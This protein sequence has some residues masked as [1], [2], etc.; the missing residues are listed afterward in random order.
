MPATRDI[1]VGIGKVRL[2]PARGGVAKRLAGSLRHY[3]RPG[4]ARSVRTQVKRKV[5]R[6]AA[7]EGTRFSAPASRREGRT[8]REERE[9][10]A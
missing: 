3:A 7:T 8:M 5:A 1:G 9:Y 2:R 10:E 4:S 6:A